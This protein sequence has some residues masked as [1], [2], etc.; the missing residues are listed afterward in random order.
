MIKHE[1]GKWKLYTSDGS[2]VLGVHDTQEDAIDQE[3]A[4]KANTKVSPERTPIGKRIDLAK[5][6]PPHF[7]KKT[8][9]S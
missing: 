9:L 1:N 6:T 8:S 5:R 7:Q 3:A 4:I 2:R